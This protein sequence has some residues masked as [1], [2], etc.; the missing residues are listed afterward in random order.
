[1]YTRWWLRLLGIEVG[2]RTEVSTAV[3]LNRLV[4]IGATSFVADDVVFAGTRARGGRLDV[5]PIVVGDRTFLG[6]GAILRAGT[7]LGNDSLVGVL[8][9]PPLQSDD[10]TTWLGLPALDLPRVPERTDPSRTTEPPV[11]LVAARGAVELVRIVLPGTVTVAIAA[12]VFA[13]LESVGGRDGGAWLLPSAPIVVLVASLCAVSITIGAKWLLIGCYKPGEHPLWSL[14]VWRDEL[15]N[16][17]HEQLAGTWL[18]STALGTP[19]LPAYLRAMG[20]KVGKGVWFETLAVTEFDLVEL[21]EGCAVNRGACVETHLFHDRLLRMGPAVLGARSTLGPDSA[22]LPHTALGDR[23][24]V[25]AR[26]VVLRGERL[27]PDTRWHGAPVQ[28][29]PRPR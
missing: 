18:L 14:F 4:R 16:T 20:S 26:S 8:S 9:S 17:L 15:V 27:P 11:R 10:G 25:G 3:G 5:A 19:V 13:A 7:R 21:G 28:S 1:V 22:V 23:C 2:R 6:N 24:S 12:L 29:Q